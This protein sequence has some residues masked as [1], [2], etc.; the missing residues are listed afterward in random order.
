MRAFGYHRH[1][2]M[3]EIPLC[4]MISSRIQ[5]LATTSD[6]GRRGSPG[7]DNETTGRDRSL[8]YGGIGTAHGRR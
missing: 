4:R 6:W 1:L 2:A 7:P 3:D 5:R 8:L